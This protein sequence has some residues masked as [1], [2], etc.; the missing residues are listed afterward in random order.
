MTEYKRVYLDTSPIIYRI[1]KNA[2]FSGLVD[3]FISN[4]TDAAFY[5]STI[6]V[7]EYSVYPIKED[8]EDLLKAFDGFVDVLG[9]DIRVIDKEIAVKAANIR[10]SY[11]HFK[12]MDALQLATA[13][14]CG[15]DVF[16]TND[17][18]L[19]QFTELNVVLVSELQ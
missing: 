16:L 9:I 19:K 2:D 14:V 4:N 5:T 3:S 17:Q 1:E 18:Q 10:A 11:N 6:T 8:R 7:E 13:V 15:C 12:A